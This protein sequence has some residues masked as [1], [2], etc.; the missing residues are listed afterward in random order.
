[1]TGVP[2]CWT[3]A[4]EGAFRN[5]ETVLAGARSTWSFVP[6]IGFRRTQ[7]LFEQR[8]CRSLIEAVRGNLRTNRAG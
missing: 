8:R 7:R 4:P 6:R 2:K 5:L 3:E 1:M